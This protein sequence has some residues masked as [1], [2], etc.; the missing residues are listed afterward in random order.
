MANLDTVWTANLAAADAEAYDRFVATASG[1]HFS[2]TRAW[3]AVAA[4]AKPCAVRYFLARR[5]GRVVGAAQVVRGHIL[6]PLPFARVDRGPV[7]ND[8]RDV[9]D[10]AAALVAEARCHGVARLSVMPYWADDAARIASHALTARGFTDTQTV[11]GSH[12]RALRL[13]LATLSEGEAFTGSDFTKLR[14]EL[15]RAERAGATARRGTEQDIDAYRHFMGTREHGKRGPGEAY[16][17]ALK[18]YF[19]ASRS[20]RAIF[21]GCHDGEAVSVILAARHGPVTFYVAGAASERDLSFS[22]M[23]QPMSQAVLWA[24]EN[25]SIAFDFGGMPMEGDTDHKRNAIAAF[26]RTFSRTE[27]A[28]VHEHVRWF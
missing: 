17:D 18:N 5:D 6:A 2:Q 21:V 24:K 25:G 8:P 4:N 7:C 12:V 13:D 22:K 10:V 15:R 16:Y 9:A 1:S 28:L 11:A 23:I 14:K 3:A 19:S 27:I 20:D 26:K